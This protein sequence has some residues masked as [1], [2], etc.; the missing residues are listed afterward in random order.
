MV[1][2]AIIAAAGRGTRFLP[3]TK[4][5]PKELLPIGNYPA[6]HYLLEECK[7]SGIEEVCIVVREW[8]SLTEQY[9]ERDEGL[10]RHLQEKGKQDLLERIHNP[11]L[12]LR[13]EFE[14]QREDLPLGHGAPVLS[15][16]SFVDKD[17]F[18][19]LFCDD[20]VHGGQPAVSALIKAWE[21]NQDLS[22]VIMT[23]QVPLEEISKFS[24][25]K[26]AETRDNGV[27]L[28]ADYIEKPT[29]PDQYFEPEC[30][31]GRAVYKADLFDSLQEILAAGKL[32]AGEFSTWDAMM[33]MNS[34]QGMG[35]IPVP[36]RWL[37]T[38]T[39]EQ[40]NE[41]IKAIL[42]GN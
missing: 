38:G 11:G 17:N 10:E 3:A 19:L 41:A 22:G 20:L 33:H 37:T 13:I 40:M 9:F 31:V 30:F 8:G 2:K 15:A 6:I 18:A 32:A 23:S 39:P 24:T 4:I 36:G 28:I 34:K 42:F 21:Q 29:S 5:I 12:G 7:Q 27:K 1:K 16:R 14:K 26:Y 35:A 25:V